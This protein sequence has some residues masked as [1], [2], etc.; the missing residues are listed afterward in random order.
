M[1]D[2]PE[3]PEDSEDENSQDSQE[4]QDSQSSTEE[5]ASYEDSS[6]GNSEDS[7]VDPQDAKQKEKVFSFWKAIGF[8][9]LGITAFVVVGWIVVSLSPEK[10]TNQTVTPQDL[11]GGESAP[12]VPQLNPILSPRLRNSRNS[13]AFGT[14]SEENQRILNIPLTISV[15]ISDAKISF[16][17][18]ETDY[19]KSFSI[20]EDQCSILESVKI[21]DTCSF[22]VVWNPKEFT[23][24]EGSNLVLEVSVPGDQI[25]SED[26]QWATFYHKIPMTGAYLSPAK[27]LEISLDDIDFGEIETNQLGKS[28]RQSSFLTLQN[29]KIKILTISV[30]PT[31][32]TSGIGVS[33]T[34]NCPEEPQVPP[35]GDEFKC[36]FVLT[37][38]ANLLGQRIENT[39]EILWT[40]P[41]G[42]Q[43][44]G[45]SKYNHSKNHRKNE[46]TE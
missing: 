35:N 36:E 34:D 11:I 23:N 19:P 21:R 33:E 29:R 1:A 45:I 2:N 30:I 16:F 40:N 13:L 31:S 22:E 14:L 9:I 5:D 28:F 17:A 15:T 20:E 41:E 42:D 25:N 27:P 38:Q 6:I 18:F 37:W 12:E 32:Q 44:T 39:L 10:D 24:L 43:N 26:T 3:N 4:S 7:D 8:S 46:I